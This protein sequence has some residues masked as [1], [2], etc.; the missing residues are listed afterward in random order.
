M[1]HTWHKLSL[2]WRNFSADTTIYQ[3]PDFSINQQYP[4]VNIK[5]T[6]DTDYTIVSTPAVWQDYVVVG[7]SAGR[8]YGLFLKN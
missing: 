2:E 3:R 8:V 7:N 5:W 1:L 6:Y 4:E